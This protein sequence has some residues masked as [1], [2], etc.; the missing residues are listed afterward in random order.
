[1]PAPY[2]HKPAPPVNYQSMIVLPRGEDLGPKVDNTCTTEESG[3]LYKLVE[4]EDS[5]KFKVLSANEM[6][7][8]TE[9]CKAVASNMLRLSAQFKDIQRK[10]HRGS[11]KFV[12]P[13]FGTA[14]KE[15]ATSNLKWDKEHGARTMPYKKSSA[16]AEAYA[17][18]CILP[19]DALSLSK[20][21]TSPSKSK[22]KIDPKLLSSIEEIQKNYE[23]NLGVIEKLYHEK[24]EMK[25]RIKMLEGKLLLI[26]I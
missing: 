12:P 5:K 14:K 26:Y 6:D 10:K 4:A 17:T 13:T 21:K 23:K 22:G 25:N 7:Q 15:V 9:N 16:Y 24:L 8:E 18:Q 19:D 3:I 20:E 1:M 11:A 2:Q